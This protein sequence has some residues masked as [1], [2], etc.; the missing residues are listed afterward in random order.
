MNKTYIINWHN[1]EVMESRAWS[2]ICIK[3]IQLMFFIFSTRTGQNQ[4]FNPVGEF[5]QWCS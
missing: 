3:K 4:W 1:K 5:V 2:N